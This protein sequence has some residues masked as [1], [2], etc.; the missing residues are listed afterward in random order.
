MKAS[1]VRSRD[2]LPTTVAGNVFTQVDSLVNNLFSEVWGRDNLNL[3]DFSYPKLNMVDKDNVLTIQASVPGLTDKEISV[4]WCEGVLA[5]KGN[6]INDKEVKNEDYILRELHKSSFCRTIPL[7][8]DS[9]DINKVSAK[10]ENGLLTVNVPKKAI[11]D[12][13]PVVKKILVEK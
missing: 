8:E 3:S 6:S 9:Y 13:R 7:L 5:I 1:K 12:N 4:E 10:V 11:E 2:L